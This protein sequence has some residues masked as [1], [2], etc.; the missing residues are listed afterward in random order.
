MAIILL[1]LMILPT[2]SALLPRGPV[3]YPRYEG[4]LD[5][6]MKLMLAEHDQDDVFRSL[7]QFKSW[8]IYEDI[9][10]AE[11]IGLKNIATMKVL[12][13]AL[14]EG[15]KQEFERLSGYPRT[16]W[17]EY[18][19]KMELMM[20]Q[21]LST[22][23]ATDA[24]NSFIQSAR[25]KFPQIT[26]DGVTVAVVDTGI[27]AGHPDLDYKEKTIINLKHALSTRSRTR[28]RATVTEPTAQVLSPVTVM[29]RPEPGLV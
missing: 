14:L 20:E 11:K 3:V 5:P 25:E 7:V 8:P 22:I 26:G 23:N 9:E 2:V 16:Y 21:S 6:Y 4:T 17:M 15:T 24:W 27:D 12:P 19:G 10:Y 1:G 29:L 13:A 18:D 28:I